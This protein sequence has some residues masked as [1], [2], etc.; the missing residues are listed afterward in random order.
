[1]NK[2]LFFSI[3]LVLVLC[4]ASNASAAMLGWWTFDDST[5]DD[6][7]G[8]GH[9]GTLRV[10][11][12]NTVTFVFDV[13]RDS[14]VAA[15]PGDPCVMISVG[16]GRALQTD[17]CTWADFYNKDTQT[18]ALWMKHD[19]LFFTSYEYAFAKEPAF[20]VSRYSSSR[21]MRI[22]LEGGPDGSLD[23]TLQ[24]TMTTDDG[25]W[26]HYA[27][28][29]DGTTKTI[30]WDG[31]IN[32]SEPASGRLNTTSVHDVTIGGHP[33][34]SVRVWKGWLD[35]VRMYDNAYPQF[36]IR[37]W[38]GA[39]DT[40][41]PVPV[42]G[43]VYQEVSL[44]QLSWTGMGGT[45]NYRLYIGTDFDDV[46][47]G[48][49]SVDKG[50]IPGTTMNYTGAP[51]SALAYATTYYWKTDSNRSGTVYP[52]DIWEFTTKPAWTEDPYPFD[53]CKYVGLAQ[54]FGWK[55]GADSIKHEV[56]F[57]ANEQWVIDACDSIQT[58]IVAPDPCVYSPTLAVDTTYY[59][60]VDSN[61]GTLYSEGQIWSLSTDA[62]SPEPG[63]VGYYPMDEKDG[64]GTL[65]WDIS[66][67]IHHGT[68]VQGDVS[69]SIDIVN[70]TDR[71]NVLK[72][73]TPG[74][75]ANSALD[76]GG[77]VDDPD[78]CWGYVAQNQ[79]TVM[80]WVKPEEFHGTD[81]IYTRGNNIQ[82]RNTYDVDPPIQHHQE[83]CFYSSTLDDASTW[84]PVSEVGEWQHITITWENYVVSDVNAKKVYVN[85]ALKQTDATTGPG[86][87]DPLATHVDNLVIGGRL[88]ATYNDR[89]YD[90][91]LDD[92]KIYDIVLPCWKIARM[93][94][95]CGTALG[96]LDANSV[97]NLDDLNQ[98]VGDLTSAKM[99]SGQWLIIEGDVQTGVYWKNCSDMD[100]DDD[101]D[102]ADLNRMV[103]NLT[104]E[105]ITMDYPGTWSYPAGKYCP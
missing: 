78:P 47:N 18:L 13:E 59:W 73:D 1:M 74:G 42:D 76:L 69:T 7:S 51:M 36:I 100:N 43:A 88:N 2:R 97:I 52:G 64:S 65:T 21:N 32:V 37:T 48:D 68:L 67:N 41:T 19:G 38:I 101:I 62:T 54:Q 27:A 82:L 9:H 39:Y 17:P 94:A 6:T 58:T 77:N 103:G 11:G 81:Y 60:K 89:G 34:N 80:M 12:A 22:Y 55:G 50:E 56:F 40:Y 71:G 85:G 26:H 87:G 104:W 24:G 102:L 25:Q 16:G 57:S 83:I 5:A 96:D 20:R 4:L 93:V 75:V 72:T 70:D 79:M 61:S 63:L 15:F 91:L 99:A 29:Y 14:N 98:L 92:V 53:G 86:G 35:D 44:A 30:Y 31:E 95:E 23:G 66:G 33:G 10:V 84:G 49:A 46:N 45:S 8:A 3:S 28:V 90:G 105:E